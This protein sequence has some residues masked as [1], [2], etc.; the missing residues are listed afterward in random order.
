M[1]KFLSILLCFA[2]MSSPTVFTKQAASHSSNQ[3]PS[4]STSESLL[5]L[6]DSI[7]SGYGVETKYSYGAIV[8]ENL[9]F[10]LTNLAYEG[11][12]TDDL[13]EQL[14]TEE[15]KNAVKTADYIEIS[16][17]GNDFL[18]NGNEFIEN[19]NSGG[20]AAVA[21]TVKATTANAKN[22]IYTVIKKINKQNP[23]VKIIFQTLYVT[24]INNMQNI[25]EVFIDSF[26]DIYYDAQKDFDN[27]Y[28]CDIRSAFKNTDTDCIASDEVHPN[29]FGHRLIAA[30]LTELFETLVQMPA[31]NPAQNN[32][33]DK[34]NVQNVEKSFVKNIYMFD[35]NFDGKTDEKDAML[36][37]H[38]LMRF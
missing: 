36:I 2:V 15:C 37:L 31:Y 19:F 25:F 30:K 27:V 12:Q 11:K 5:L 9:G 4:V 21:K 20:V 38:I 24:N 28:V 22:N 1:S 3:N 34:Q 10:N 32:Q 17:G 6:G 33:A 14:N 8:S 26:N 35:I 13:A 18:L 29:Y 16:I 23:D 7:A